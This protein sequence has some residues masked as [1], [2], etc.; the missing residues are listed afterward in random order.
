MADNWHK[1]NG[2]LTPKPIKIYKLATIEEAIETVREL[3]EG[4]HKAEGIDCL[5]TAT[6]GGDIMNL[7]KLPIR[8]SKNYTF[9][10]P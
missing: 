5:V 6:W 4:K 7:T 10:P 1:A 9:V 8:Y 2:K 3:A